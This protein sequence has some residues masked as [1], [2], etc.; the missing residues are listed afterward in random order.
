[1]GW[2]KCVNIRDHIMRR[3][4]QSCITDILFGI[5]GNGA[6]MGWDGSGED[7]EETNAR[8]K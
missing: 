8:Q 6:R 5:W 3:K 4:R 7:R 2:G 1:M